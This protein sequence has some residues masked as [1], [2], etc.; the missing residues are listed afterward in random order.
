MEVPGSSR[1]PGW[2]VDFWMREWLLRALQTL[3]SPCWAGLASSAASR[4]HRSPK[5]HFVTLS[6]ESF[7]SFQIPVFPLSGVIILW[8]FLYSEQGYWNIYCVP[9]RVKILWGGLGA[10]APPPAWYI[11][12]C[13]FWVNEPDYQYS[14][15]SKWN[16]VDWGGAKSD[17]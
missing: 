9:S 2:N 8:S 3:S 12:S 10:L 17:F 4:I 1:E 7:P 11:N 5:I 13:S 15:A 16:S 14:P 6:F